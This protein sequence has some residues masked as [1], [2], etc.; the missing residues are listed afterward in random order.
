MC[1]GVP[2]AMRS[3]SISVDY[4]TAEGL[5]AL[6]G[7]KCTHMFLSYRGV[8]EQHSEDRQEECTVK[9]S[10]Q[11]YLA[12]RGLGKLVSGICPPCK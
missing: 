12:A 8:L 4:A 3:L 9:T 5:A 1:V 2:E 6:L 11:A 10:V 7:V